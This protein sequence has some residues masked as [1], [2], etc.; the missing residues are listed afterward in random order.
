[1]EPA[2]HETQTLTHEPET[3]DQETALPLVVKLRPVINLSEDQFFELCQINRD[4]RIERN[5]K[6]EI[7]FMPPT[8]GGAGRRNAEVNRQL[9]NWAKD[10]GT[11][12]TFDSSTGFR[13]PNMAVRSPDAWMLRS[14]LAQIPVERFIPAGPDFVVELRSSSDTLRT[15]QDKMQEDVDNGARLGWLI[16]PEPRQVYVYR[17]ETP[18]ERLDSPEIISGDPVLPGFV[19]DLREIW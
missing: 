12:V 8:G 5:A 16:D 13:L 1:M 15:V 4:L 11:G 9:A 10:N 2:V 6:G 18:V 3:L 7:L 14:R 19:L 17:P